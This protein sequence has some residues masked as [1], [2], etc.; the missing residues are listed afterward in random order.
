MRVSEIR[1]LSF[2]TS[3]DQ[4]RRKW[5][6]TGTNTKIE[7]ITLYPNE[8]KGCDRRPT[9]KQ[10]KMS[11]QRSVLDV[12]RRLRSIRRGAHVG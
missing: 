3:V 6:G 7:T 2:T 8:R 12:L 9:S 10:L 5:I 11:N 4:L 1:F